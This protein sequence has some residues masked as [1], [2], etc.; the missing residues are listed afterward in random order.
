MHKRIP[1]DKLIEECIEGKRYAQQLLFEKYRSLMFAICMRYAKSKAEAEDVMVDGF[2]KIYS[3]LHEFKKKGSFE[4]WLKRIMVNTAIN[5]YRANIKHYYNT[6]IDDE[7]HILDVDSNEDQFKTSYSAEYLIMLIQNLPDGYRMVFNLYEI[8]GFSHKEVAEIMG[9]SVST[10]K[11][12]LFYAKK[13]LQ[14]KLISE[15]KKDMY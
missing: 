2:M 14:K 10:A 15:H 6:S 9:I 12:Q 11:T 5:N 1:E 3:S 7:E 8:E 13:T 4:G